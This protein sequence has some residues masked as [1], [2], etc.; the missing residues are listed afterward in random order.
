MIP[1]E[2]L[3]GIRLLI[4]DLDGTLVDSELDLALSVNAVRRAM[5]LDPLPV[6]TV[7]SYVGQG[8]T[9]LIRRALGEAP[10]AET[11]ENATAMFLKYYGEHMLD[12]TVPYDGVREALAGLGGKPLAVLTNKPVRFSTRLLTGLD[13][14]RHFKWIYG[15]DSFASKK[16]DPV[17]VYKL[18]NDLG[19]SPRTT[20]IVGD[21]DTDVLT[22][23]NAGVWTCGVTYGIGSRTLRGT[24]PD[25]LLDDLRELPPLLNGKKTREGSR[26]QG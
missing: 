7:A 22:G 23:Q 4:F 25:L 15:G 18:M 10:S 12:N 21:S 9:A 26:K 16:P 19:A 8:V 14:A 17:G 6:A 24:P 1:P 2:S 11:L 5:G 13:L 20:L 3:D